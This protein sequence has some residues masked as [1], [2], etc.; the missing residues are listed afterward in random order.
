[1]KII[2]YE[3]NSIKNL[4]PITLTRPGF[5]IFCAGTN[6]YHI[7]TKQLKPDS[8]DYKIRD[9]LYKTTK[10][11]Y[12]PNKKPDNKIIFLDSGL[13]PD[14]KSAQ[15]LSAIIK[16]NKNIIFKN[17]NQITG[18]YLD[19]EK[20]A[21]T[22]SK[23][24][25]LKHNQV[26][27]FI[28]KLK[29]KTLEINWPCYNYL[30]EPISYNQ[31]LLTSNLEF[32]K[33]EFKQ[34][35][36]KVFIGKNVDINNQVVFN[37]DNGPIII[38]NDTKI[39]PFCYLQGPIYIGKNCLVHE[40]TSI[41]NNCSIGNVCRAGGEI[42]NSIMSDYSNKQ[43][44]GF[45]GHSFI[46]SWANLAAGTTNSNLKNTYS[47]VKMNSVNSGE[48]FLG[49]IVGDNSK[50]AINTPIYTGKIIGVYSYIFSPVIENIPSFTSYIKNIKNSIEF[51]LETA[52]RIQKT[53]MKRRGVTQT[54]A[55]QELLKH[56]FKLTENER[57]Q[58]NIKPGKIKLT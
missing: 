18:A 31:K 52:I 12:Q 5:D 25:S 9:Y 44:Y 51:K 16:K 53:P 43:H 36:P 57:N 21:I 48:Q 55:D 30:H 47:Y 32:I 14:F 10:A 38:N 58:L 46:G 37:T 17:K 56:V 29:L 27:D 4:Y 50:T 22:Y 34:L 39:K 11:K 41:K 7:I 42:S 26:I 8:I 13:I 45:L 35:K 6:L 2:L 15:N 1:M 24:Q 33:L 49:C 20:I 54:K 28:K 40:F 3:H 19:L 23:I